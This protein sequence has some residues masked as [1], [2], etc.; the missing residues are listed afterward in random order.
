MKVDGGHDRSSQGKS[1]APAS[2]DSP[3][4]G[5]RAFSTAAP[6]TLEYSA[7]TC[8]AESGRNNILLLYEEDRPQ[9]RGIFTQTLLLQNPQNTLE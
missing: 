2:Y 3:A 8:L 9:K 4:Y 6:K 1:L 7:S 5:D